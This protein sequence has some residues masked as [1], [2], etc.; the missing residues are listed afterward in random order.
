MRLKR[1]IGLLRRMPAQQTRNLLRLDPADFRHPVIIDAVTTIQKQHSLDHF[2]DSWESLIGF[3]R[4]GD[5]L[6]AR[7]F[8]ELVFAIQRQLVQRSAESDT[9]KLSS[10]SGI[11]ALLS[12]EETS[13]TEAMA[14]RYYHAK[15]IEQST[16]ILKKI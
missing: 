15:R 2:F 14:T 6:F 9:K 4:V 3:Q 12:L 5:P 16:N 8:T 11:D 13:Y 7:E 1:A 10:M